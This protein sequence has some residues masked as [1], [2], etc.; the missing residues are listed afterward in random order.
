MRLAYLFAVIGAFLL[1]A[2]LS[3]GVA[4]VGA[5]QVEQQSVASVNSMMR[6]QGLDWVEIGADGLRVVLAGT[7]P[8]E[9]ARFHALRAAGE[10]VDSDRVVDTMHV[11]DPEGIE[12]PR[13]SLEMLRNED[14]VSLIGLIPAAQGRESLT[15]GIDDLAAGLHV[16]NMVEIA[17]F[18]IPENWS[19]A[20]RFGLQALGELPRAKVSVFDGQVV[21]E[22]V[23]DSPAQK[24]EWEAFLRNNR[25]STID[26][27]MD[28]S[29]PRPVITPFTLRYVQT[30]EGGHFEACSAGTEDS[31]TRILAAARVA[32]LTGPDSCRIGLGVPSPNW[33]A[34]VEQALSAV[35]RFE[36]ATVTFSDADITLI[37][38]QGTPAPLFDEVIGELDAALPEVFSLHA[39][40]PPPPPEQGNEDGPPTFTATR[41]PEGY[42]QLR[43]RLPDDRITEAVQAYGTA[44]FGRQNTYL[45][46]RTDEELPTGWSLRVLAGLEALSHLNNGA[47]VVEPDTV[48][49]TGNSGSEDTT[50]DLSQLMGDLLGESEGF[51]INVTYQASLD[52]QTGLPTPQQCLDRVN[53][54][55]SQRKITFDP[56]SVE[57]NEET[58]HILDDLAEILPDC[59]H[60]QM[61]IGG[62]TD[63]QGREEMNLRLSQGRADAVL[64]GLLAR[65]VLTSN[66]TA[67]GYGETRPIASNETEEG[68]ETNRRIEF[69]LA[70]DVAE[71]DAREAAEARAALLA[72]APRPVMRPDNLV[73]DAGEENTE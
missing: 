63:S 67:H 33:P 5:K 14:G 16:A 8:D 1:A 55:L 40:L 39:V 45:A 37:V 71:R 52:P 58:G 44:L 22:A 53:T 73:P 35:S 32:G 61:E 3:L 50:S 18:P 4:V 27:V 66:L 70:S 60:V 49:I 51:E 57:I 42:V 69:L 10:V 28:I 23:S 13:F 68:R 2:V 17:D 20:L 11:L 64:N 12:P 38:A 31:R 72:D 24:A 65:R 43:G 48:R 47:V 30:P 21:V 62:H 46:T 26:L 9:A 36:N 25:P 41:S 15:Q 29:A 6:Q 56:G 7:A 59:S 19:A 34:A 54:V